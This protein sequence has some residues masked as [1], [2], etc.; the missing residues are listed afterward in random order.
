MVNKSTLSICIGACL[1]GAQPVIALAASSAP[2]NVS[3]YGAGQGSLDGYDPVVDP[4]TGELLSQ[5][6]AQA[7][8]S[9]Q[10]AADPATV[11]ST[12]AA[13]AT[14]PSVSNITIQGSQQAHQPAAWTELPNDASILPL[15]DEVVMHADNNA[16]PIPQMQ[17]ATA[18]AAAQAANNPVE[19]AK[20]AVAAGDAQ[21]EADAKAAAAAKAKAEAEE[22]QA[23]ANAALKAA[24]EARALE[25]AKA[26]QAQMKAEQEKQE[27]AKAAALANTAKDTDAKAKAA[28]QGK[29]AEA[30]PAA[31]AAAALAAANDVRAEIPDPK[32]PAPTPKSR[33]DAENVAKAI[34]AVKQQYSS[35]YDGPTT[36]DERRYMAKHYG[37]KSPSSTGYQYV[38]KPMLPP[39][40]AYKEAKVGTAWDSSSNKVSTYP[41]NVVAAAT[42]AAAV[43]ASTSAAVTAAAHSAANN[44]SQ[45]PFQ[46]TVTTVEQQQAQAQAQDAQAQAAQTQAAQSAQLQ[47]AQAQQATADAAAADGKAAG[48]S[49]VIAVGSDLEVNGTQVQSNQATREQLVRV[50]GTNT[51]SMVGTVEEVAEYRKGLPASQPNVG[52]VHPNNVYT[53]TDQYGNTVVVQTPNGYNLDTGVYL[54]G[55]YGFDGQPI[56]PGWIP[57][58]GWP[59]AN[60]Q[61]P[62]YAPPPGMQQPSGPVTPSTP[63]WPADPGTY[64]PAAWQPGSQGPNYAPPPGMQ[65]PPGNVVPG[66]PGWPADPGVNYVQPRK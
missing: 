10:G 18:M 11:A 19:K 48:G 60:G 36:K 20:R 25:V 31:Q 64:P 35:P 32:K 54:Y 38:A 49:K 33:A 29:N 37:A 7:L 50:Y 62:S 5:E 24:A 8:Y 58:A 56:P 1:L 14:V 45:G 59:P 44:V 39:K 16:A 4:V 13:Q 66:T 34:A 55:N 57:P 3:I 51:P 17:S 47:S 30:T 53:Y 12:G 9:I 21:R 26:K 65:P 2:D 46:G 40:P 22:A 42:A 63:G 15:G 6:D 27:K 52:Y 28:P 61:F 41:N 23:K 43:T